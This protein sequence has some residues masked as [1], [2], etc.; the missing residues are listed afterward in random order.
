MRVLILGGDG[1][2]GWP[3]AMSFSAAGHEVVVVDNFL[4]RL[5]SI[6]MGA[7]SLTPIQSLQERV[8]A[9]KD[10]S[11]RDIPAHIGD[12]TDAAF[13]EGCSRSFNL[14]RSCT[15]AS[16]RARPIR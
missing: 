16:S 14:R 11:G 10:V 1:Y 8:R 4:R 9:W 2:L 15:T 5:M 12:L 7:S 6:E 3:T 13:V